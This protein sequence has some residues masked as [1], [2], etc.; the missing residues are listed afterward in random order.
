MTNPGPPTAEV[1]EAPLRL[2]GPL[3][4]LLQRASWNLFDQILSALTNVALSFVV[5][6]QVSAASFGAFSVGFIIFGLVI[7][8]QRALI[9]QPLSIR[10]TTL[11][12]S[13]M[14]SVSESALGAALGVTIP[15]S[16]IVAA[17][18][19]VIGHALGHT[20]LAL[21]V[22]LPGLIVQDTCRMV[23]FAQRRPR[24]AAANDAAWAVVQFAAIA[25]LLAAGADE[26]WEFV[27]AWGGAATVC[28]VGGVAVLRAWPH[29]LRTVTWIREHASLGGY[30]FAEYLLGI[31][32]Y[33]GGILLVGAFLGQANIG[34]LRAALVLLGPLGIVSTAMST[35]L[36]PEVSR[37]PSLP[38]GTRMKVALGSSTALVLITAV[39]VAILLLLPRSVG[40]AMLGDTWTGAREV[41]LPMA[42]WSAAASASAGPAMMLYAMGLARSTFRLHVVAAPGV[43]I[44]FI[45]GGHINGAVGAAWGLAILSIVSLPFW[46]LQLA[47]S[48]RGHTRALEEATVPGPV[49]APDS[50]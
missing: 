31:G 50:I 17:V 9:G 39:Y 26:P 46:C 15:V 23:F 22:V 25:V 43:I 7:G 2:G 49:R 13:T 6:R 11:D 36:L 10:H 48:L 21:A 34:S 8:L 27:L 47:V 45:L 41:L 5:A 37:R 29:V 16:I 32:V 19:L 20:L 3:Q 33:Q 38:S 30:L 40:T 24:R 1:D 18:G 14:H 4:K 42:T 44:A 12:D 35:F 28:A